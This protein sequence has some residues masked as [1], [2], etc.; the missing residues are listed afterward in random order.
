MLLWH[1]A[2]AM[3][4]KEALQAENLNISQ[5]AK[6]LKI[7]QSHAS[8]IVNGKRR[9]SPELSEKIEILL[10][11]KIYRLSLLFPH[12]SQPLKTQSILNRLIKKYNDFI[13]R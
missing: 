12:D 5:F 4:L 7:S 6:A 3:N 9:P 13:R 8:R 10:N 11:G 2:F 1:S